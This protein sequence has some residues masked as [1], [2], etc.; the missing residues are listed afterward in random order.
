MA[1]KTEHPLTILEVTLGT[2]RKGQE[3]LASIGNSRA[4]MKSLTNMWVNKI[5]TRQFQDRAQMHIQFQADRLQGNS[6]MKSELQGQSRTSTSTILEIKTLPL[7]TAILSGVKAWPQAR[8]E[9]TKEASATK[10]SGSSCGAE[11]TNWY[12]HAVPLIQYLCYNNLSMYV[13]IL[14]KLWNWKA[15]DSIVTFNN[16]LRQN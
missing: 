12:F 14:Q 4:L 5:R 16:D 11:T 2:Q 10:S 15:I 3:Q 9:A 13:S 6:D 1:T 7:W 8:W